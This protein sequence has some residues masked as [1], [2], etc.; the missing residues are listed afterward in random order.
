MVTT[1]SGQGEVA[2]GRE[3]DHQPLAGPGAAA[4][5]GFLDRVE[6]GV[7]EQRLDERVRHQAR[8][9]EH[10]VVRIRRA[11]RPADP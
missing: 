2:G 4:D 6:L 1:S 3:R 9:D 8:V 10:R 5:L 11:G 7:G